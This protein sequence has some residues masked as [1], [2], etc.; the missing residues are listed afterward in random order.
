[1]WQCVLH[2]KW[3]HKSMVHYVNDK[4][5]YCHIQKSKFKICSEI[6]FSCTAGNFLLEASGFLA[7]IN[8]F[9]STYVLTLHM[10]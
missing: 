1:M 2:K 9:R 6:E 8:Y 10:N 7:E 4:P 5:A 3:K